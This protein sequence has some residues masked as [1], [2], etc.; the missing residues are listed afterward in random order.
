MKIKFI[1]SPTGAPYFLAYN[2]GDEADLEPAVANDL[3]AQKIARVVEQPTATKPHET[4]ERAISQQA[5]KAEK[6]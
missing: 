3:I 1:K 4:A 2:E 5:K 6:R